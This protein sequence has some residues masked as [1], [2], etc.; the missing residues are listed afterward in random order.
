MIRNLFLLTFL[1]A[2]VFPTP[3]AAAPIAP[4]AF[5]T[6]WDTGADTTISITLGDCD[7]GEDIYWEEIGNATNNGT[8]TC[9][10]GLTTI[11]FPT[12]GQYRV[13]FNGNWTSLNLGLSANRNKFRTVEQWGSSVWTTMASAFAGVTQLTFNAADTPD[14]SLVTDMSYMFDGASNFNSGIGNWDVSNVTTFFFM[15]RNAAAFN[16]PLNAWNTSSVTDI[17]GIF[18]NATSFNQPLDAWDVSGV[19]QM[20]GVFAGAT[21]FNQPLNAWDVTQVVS[22]RGEAPYFDE[23]MFAGATSFN[24][25]L[26]AWNTANA[27]DMRWM[28]NNA[29]SFNQPLNAWDVSNVAYTRGMFQN[30]TSFNQPLDAW[31]VSSVSDFQEMFFG[32]SAFDQDLGAW[33][34]EDGDILTDILRSSGLS[35]QNYANLLNTWSV[36]SPMPTGIDLGTISTTYCDTATAAHTALIDTY[37]WTVT[38]LGAAPCVDAEEES[39]SRSNGSSRYRIPS[40]T[41][42][43]ESEVSST[44]SS[45]PTLTVGNRGLYGALRDLLPYMGTNRTPVSVSP[46][47]PQDTAP[48]WRNAMSLLKHY[49]E[50]PSWPFPW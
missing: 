9:Q 12:A 44:A 49:N 31:D 28:F 27:T 46:T 10:I 25:P 4:G 8:D 11:T 47:A 29:T 39:P 45:L 43:T 24:Q 1:M 21:S 26:D 13:D 7:D 2:M 5:S 42:T 14:L 22:F 33:Q 50:N 20:H 19:T 48:L 41:M 35:S 34:I 32:A 3:A 23:G 36:Q 6:T 15:F 38:D 16:Q 40:D 37:S 17:R 30:A 18:K